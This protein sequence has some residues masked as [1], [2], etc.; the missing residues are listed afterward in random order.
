MDFLRM[1]RAKARA[2]RGLGEPSPV[3]GS[4]GISSHPSILLPWIGKRRTRFR[5]PGHPALRPP[6]TFGAV[7]L[8]TPAAQLL[9]SFTT[10][11][12]TRPL[13]FSPAFVRKFGAVHTFD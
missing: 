12:E 7:E 5:A 2:S 10:E 3:L 13:G 6:R 4:A 11:T 8:S 1:T 9:N